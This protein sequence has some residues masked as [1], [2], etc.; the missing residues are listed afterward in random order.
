MVMMAYL[1]WNGGLTKRKNNW[2]ILKRKLK[3][4][5]VGCSWEWMRYCYFGYPNYLEE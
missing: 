5:K 3:V 4:K 1:D 2:Q